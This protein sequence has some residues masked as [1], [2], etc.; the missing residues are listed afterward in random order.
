MKQILGLLTVI[1]TISCTSQNVPAAVKTAFERSFPNTTVKKWD[2]EDEDF[3]ANF[4]KDGK[5]MSATFDATGILKE[6]ETDINVSELPAPVA[7]YIKANYKDAVIKEAALIEKGQEKMY[8]AE[9]E[10]KDLLFDATG[11]FLKQEED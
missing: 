6:T 4:S 11:N 2:K 1:T 7:D 8:E 5:T 3:E 9:I 10:G